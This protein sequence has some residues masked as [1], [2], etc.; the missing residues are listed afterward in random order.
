MRFEVLTTMNIKIVLILA[1]H[2]AVFE[3]Y[4]QWFRITSYISLQMRYSLKIEVSCSSETSL[5]TN[6]TTRCN[7]PEDRHVKILLWFIICG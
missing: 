1:G 2:A 4:Y 3:Y 5:T 7:N 6:K